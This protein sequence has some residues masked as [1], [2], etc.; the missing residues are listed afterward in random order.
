M[1]KILTKYKDHEVQN[2]NATSIIIISAAITSYGR[3]HINKL[4]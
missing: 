1:L 2:L 4:N 3:I